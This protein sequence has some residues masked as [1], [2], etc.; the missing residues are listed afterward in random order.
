MDRLEAALAACDARPVRVIATTA[1]AGVH[2]VRTPAGPAVLKL[3]HHGHSGNEAGGVALMRAWAGSGA[4]VRIHASAPDWVL[5]ERLDGPLLGDLARAGQLEAA[6]DALA[7]LAQRLHACPVPEDLPLARV[8]DW[9]GA[10]FALR[11]A[12]DCPA[13]LCHNLQRAAEAARELL[14]RGLPEVALHGDLHHDNV[15]GGIAIDAKGVRGPSGFE[16]ANALRNPKGCA[17]EIGRP[18]VIRRRV[19]LFAAAMGLPPKDMALW[20]VAKCGL[21]IA[22]RAG[23]TVRDDPDAALLAALLQVSDQIAGQ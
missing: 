15:V 14:R 22:W 13:E 9:F 11:C 10:L 3:Y 19:Q 5:M 6:D 21:S 8:A 18:E 2:D 16:L 17:P 20:G 12:P 1:I 7:A 23:K 4:V